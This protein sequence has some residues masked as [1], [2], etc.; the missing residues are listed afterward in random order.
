VPD[1]EPRLEPIRKG[2]PNKPYEVLG[3]RYEPLTDD[4]PLA[5]RGLAS[6]YGRKFHGRPTSSGELYNMYAM[7]GA[8]ATMPIPSYAR[9]RNP[10]NGREVIVRINDRGPFHPGRIIDPSYTA[11]LKLDILR[12]VTPVEVER[13]TYEDIRSG[14]WQR[15]DDGT[16]LAQRRDGASNVPG[17]APPRTGPAAPEPLAGRDVVAAGAGLPQDLTPMRAGLPQAAAVQP[18]ADAAAPPAPAEGGAAPKAASKG[19]WV[20][21]GAFS[22]MD[23]AEA[24][25]QKLSLELDWMAPLLAIF[26]DAQMHRLQAGPYASR[27]DARSAAER[28]RQALALTPVIVERR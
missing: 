19:F 15:R 3:Q 6:W 7:T 24:F 20:Q 13:I 28:M 23:G 8:H 4:Q 18:P 27:E 5:E 26:K 2:G 14:A 1:A 25:R 10:A 17:A 22:R 12:G 16:R 11:A 21:L 9:V